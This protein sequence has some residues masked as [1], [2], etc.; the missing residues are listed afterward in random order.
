MKYAATS[1]EGRA[2][3]IETID[4][5]KL[6]T[7]ERYLDWCDTELDAWRR[8]AERVTY[9]LHEERLGRS[10]RPMR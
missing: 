10:R 5:Y 9:R 2:F 1:D 7:P 6:E 8:Y 3:L 4:P